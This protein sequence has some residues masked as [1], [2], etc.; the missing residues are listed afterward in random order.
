MAELLATLLMP[1]PLPL[2]LMPFARA[3][4]MPFMP[5]AGS[6]GIRAP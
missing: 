1:L 3:T 6:P 2:P 5:R 4:A